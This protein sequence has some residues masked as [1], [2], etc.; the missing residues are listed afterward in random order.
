MRVGLL[1]GTFDPPHRGHLRMAALAQRTL[2]LD[3]VLFIPCARQPLKAAPPAA[4]AF[5]RAAM[6]ALA[7]QR[8][9]SWSLCDLELARG[10]T[11]YTVETLEALRRLSPDDEFF[12]ILG[13]DAYAAFAQWRRYGKIP[14]MAAL[15]V[16][17][18]ER[19]CGRKPPEGV[20]EERVVWLGARPLALSSTRARERLRRGL[21]ARAMLPS[22]VASYA[23][24]HRLY[25]S[26]PAAGERR[27]V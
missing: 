23:R 24:K 21:D 17:P 25:E 1:G 7:I 4:S 10:G 22:A 3:R 5:H 8:R 13:S 14:R 16:V 27:I 15:A 19:G 26:R 20:S 9:P 11:S 2:S 18:R 6:V 12:L